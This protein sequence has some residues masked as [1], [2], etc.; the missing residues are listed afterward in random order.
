MQFTRN[1]L[2]LDAVRETERIVTFLQQTVQRGLRRQ[3]GVVGISGGIDSAV[4]LALSVRAFGA[5]QVVPVL[6][7]D[8]DSDPLSEKLGR[9]LAAALGVEPVL[10]DITGATRLLRGSFQL[11]IPPRVTKP[12]SHCRRICCRPAR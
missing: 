4:V 10:E 11:M 1:A 8:Q 5:A 12:K 2:N 3:G 9:E 6:M 7:P